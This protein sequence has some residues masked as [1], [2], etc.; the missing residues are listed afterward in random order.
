[1]FCIPLE[2]REYPSSFT[3]ASCLC[4]VDW[5][6]YRKC[7]YSSSM[8]VNVSM[9]LSAE[10]VLFVL[11]HQLCETE[12]LGLLCSHTVALNHDSLT[13]VSEPAQ[14]WVNSIL[15][16]PRRHHSTLNS[17]APTLRTNRD[18]LPLC[19]HVPVVLSWF[20]SWLVPLHLIFHCETWNR[21]QRNPVITTSNSV[22]L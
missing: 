8:I 3:V 9:W 18:W 12:N 15:A 4:T 5:Q 21:S 2:P 1:M 22:P 16:I 19:L 20:F 14:A 10:Q 17:T 13:G 11:K 7:S 6:H